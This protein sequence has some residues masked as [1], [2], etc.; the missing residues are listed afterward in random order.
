MAIAF[1]SATGGTTP[2]MPSGWQA[3]DILVFIGGSSYDAA[4]ATPTGFTSLGIFGVNIRVAWRRLQAGDTT[5]NQNC[6]QS[7]STCVVLLAYSGCPTSGD[8]WDASA[9]ATSSPISTTT[10]EADTFLVLAVEVG[11][12]D[13]LPAEPSVT[14]GVVS[15]S[16]IS[17]YHNADEDYDGEG[18]PY[19]NRI[20]V[21]SDARAA[22][23]GTGN[24]T[25]SGAHAAF[26]GALKQSSGTEAYNG[27]SSVSGTGSV[28]TSYTVAKTGTATASASTDT[29]VTGVN[30]TYDKFAT[31]TLSSG[32]EV[33]AVGEKGP[34]SIQL[35]FNAADATIPQVGSL[36][37]PAGIAPIHV[38]GSWWISP[39]KLGTTQTGIQV[40]SEVFPIGMTAGLA[41]FV[42]NPL[43]ETSYIDSTGTFSTA[44]R[45][46]HSGPN[47]N[48]RPLINLYLYR[49]SSNTVVTTIYVGNVGELGTSN[50]G[51]ASLIWTI[52]QNDPESYQGDMTL[53]E[54]PAGT[55]QTGDVLVLEIWAFS[56]SSTTQVLALDHS[57]CWI[58][59]GWGRL[60]WFTGIMGGASVSSGTSAAVT[61]SP[62]KTGTATVSDTVTVT[63]E[64]KNP[65]A[66][67]VPIAVTGTASASVV[68]TRHQNISVTAAGSSA[69]VVNGERPLPPTNLEVQYAAFGGTDPYTGVAKGRMTAPGD[70]FIGYR[71]DISTGD[72]VIFKIPA[73]NKLQSNSVY[74]ARLIITPVHVLTYDNSQIP[75]GVDLFKVRKV[76]ENPDLTS[77]SVDG[78]NLTLTGDYATV[79]TQPQWLSG[80]SSYGYESNSVWYTQR[81]IPIDPWEIDIT[82]L[83]NSFST[84]ED[85]VFAL[86]CVCTNDKVVTEFFGSHLAALKPYVEVQHYSGGDFQILHKDTCLPTF[87]CTFGSGVSLV[88]VKWGYDLERENELWADNE[89]GLV[90]PM[91]DTSSRVYVRVAIDYGPSQEGIRYYYRT[92]KTPKAP[93]PKLTERG[94]YTWTDVRRPMQL[95]DGMTGHAWAML[96]KDA[97]GWQLWRATDFNEENHTPYN[98]VKFGYPSPNTVDPIPQPY[99]YLEYGDSGP[100]HNTGESHHYPI[101]DLNHTADDISHPCFV[102]PDQ[103]IYWLSSHYNGATGQYDVRVNEILNFFAY[104]LDWR[105]SMWPQGWQ[106]QSQYLTSYATAPN[107]KD[108]SAV[109]R[110]TSRKTGE[111]TD[112]KMPL[113]AAIHHGG[114]TKIWSKNPYNT[115]S[116][117]NANSFVEE[118]SFNTALTGLE[119]LHAVTHDRQHFTIFVGKHSSGVGYIA[120]RTDD[121]ITHSSPNTLTRSSSG[122]WTG[123]EVSNFKTAYVTATTATRAT[124]HVPDIHTVYLALVR[125]NGV[126]QFHRLDSL[127][128][129]LVGQGESG[130]TDYTVNP[131]TPIFDPIPWANDGGGGPPA[132]TNAATEF[133]GYVVDR[134]PTVPT[135]TMH[136][137]QGGM[138]GISVSGT[139]LT[140]QRVSD[141]LRVSDEK[142]ITVASGAAVYVPNDAMEG[143]DNPIVV[144]TTGSY[145]IYTVSVATDMALMNVGMAD[146][147]RGWLMSGGLLEDDFDDT[148]ATNCKMPGLTQLPGYNTFGI[149]HT[150]DTGAVPGNRGLMD[151]GGFFYF[152]ISNVQGKAPKIHVWQHPVGA[153]M[154][155]DGLFMGP[156]GGYVGTPELHSGWEWPVCKLSTWYYTYDPPTYPNRRWHVIWDTD[157]VMCGESN[158]GKLVLNL[159]PCTS[160]EVYICDVI[161]QDIDEYEAN[162]AVWRQ[163]PLVKGVNANGEILRLDTTDTIS[164]YYTDTLGRKLRTWETGV[165]YESSQDTSGDKLLGFFI[166]N[167]QV[168]RDRKKLVYIQGGEDPGEQTS[169]V[170]LY[171]MVRELLDPESTL[172][173]RLLAQYSFLFWPFHA[174]AATRDGQERIPQDRYYTT[175][176]VQYVAPGYELPWNPGHYAGWGRQSVIG[177]MGAKAAAE[178]WVELFHAAGGINST[179]IFCGL[180][181]HCDTHNRHGTS[182]DPTYIFRTPPYL[183]LGYFDRPTFRDGFDEVIWPE[184]HSLNKNLGSAGGYGTTGIGNVLTAN[185]G[186]DFYWELPWRGPPH[187]QGFWY[188]KDALDN[189]GVSFLRGINLLT[190]WDA[191]C[192]PLEINAVADAAST[193]TKA[194]SATVT[195]SAAASV[196]ATGTKA[197]LGTADVNSVTEELVEGTTAHYGTATADAAADA[198]ATETR[199]TSAEVTVDAEAIID[200]VS[201]RSVFNELSE[202]A[203]ADATATGIK[204]GLG[205]AT[206]DAT[207]DA[208]ASYSPDKTGTASLDTLAEATPVGAKQASGTTSVDA[209]AEAAATGTLLLVKSGTASVD[210]AAEATA[211]ATSARSGMLALGSGAA[212]V[213]VGFKTETF[214]Q[215]FGTASLSSAASADALATSQRYATDTVSAL[216]M[217]DV[218]GQALIPGQG[219]SEVTGTADV[220][221][222]PLAERYGT[223]SVAAGADVLVAYS[224]F[225]WELTG[226]ALVDALTD[227]QVLYAPGK[228]GEATVTAVGLVGSLGPQYDVSARVTVQLRNW[229]LTVQAKANPAIVIVKRLWSLLAQKRR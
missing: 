176:G 175:E 169:H 6:W 136:A 41:R 7:D 55:I 99:T 14:G 96:A 34:S 155:K 101:N 146:P 152:K 72:R 92:F 16:R 43:K 51:W 117:I 217:A 12:W 154:W 215:V 222:T 44:V 164:D 190:S 204:T 90:W 49:P 165:S 120:R 11:G 32:T 1:R 193:G 188:T 132:P 94:T 160:D 147:E 100:S 201:G 102:Q 142:T 10:T 214:L 57:S 112:S 27:T 219:T 186:E 145:K 5:I 33:T 107:L 211:T 68:V 218:I 139:T 20:R 111:I 127:G 216:A 173:R 172:G 3:N 109:T 15:T 97:N 162:I 58:N 86:E 93:A 166:E 21:Y 159:P 197:A 35:Y 228:T 45:W 179:G 61:Y 85:M 163:N 89:S 148:F 170:P 210:A 131:M 40:N 13:N 54:A 202:S 187:K 141:Y 48:T 23:G 177:G 203:T 174:Q 138:V 208:T 180:T 9:G 110:A 62:G 65:L 56:G 71:K 191:Y 129:A 158:G 59:F 189:L 73:A 29:T 227:A 118:R 88:A 98:F 25:F 75:V 31:L 103:A 30:T 63:C 149:H 60:D 4:P 2:G 161:L 22:S 150:W 67:K 128:T 181:L 126:V 83:Y 50:G 156:G 87:S 26:L 84:Q 212:A 74:K 121:T 124:R 104:I 80:Q 206:V 37:A 17:S 194:T 70:A 140:A 116:I 195:F 184:Y 36:P 46:W 153:G 144:G 105:N 196:A 47:S 125:T 143:L 185:G 108:L 168:P 226:T 52:D 207:A 123:G 151:E 157:W 199:W 182:I 134:W 221:V 95:S 205:A 113:I 133:A 119:F 122:S 115:R 81:A 39:R 38:A 28:S 200:I 69:V 198:T 24:C 76:T 18:F 137:E 42:S 223:T 114:T 79:T 53:G 66:P 135:I 130:G 178:R 224:K 106:Y 213:A 225:T 183:Y 8:P 167:D 78:M 229:G 77:P 171:A 192:D 209:T 82:T 220:S 64:G 19:Y 91:L